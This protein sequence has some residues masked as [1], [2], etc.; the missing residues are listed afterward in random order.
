MVI[1]ESRMTNE[2]QNASRQKNMRVYLFYLVLIWILRDLKTHTLILTSG[3]VFVMNNI[4]EKDAFIL[5]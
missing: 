2:T 4:T 3:D 1:Y 5:Y